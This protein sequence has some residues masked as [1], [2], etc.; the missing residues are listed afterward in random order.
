MKISKLSKLAIASFITFGGLQAQT[1][2]VPK[3][4]DIVSKII[5]PL[6]PNIGDLG[7][8]IKAD[9]LKGL[10][11]E[12]NFD[13]LILQVRKVH[14]EN[15]YLRTDLTIAFRNDKNS[16]TEDASTGNYDH[17]E[18]SITQFSIGISPGF[19]YHYAGTKRLS[20]YIG[21]AVPIAFVGKTK[22]KETFD[23]YYSNGT[24]NLST[25][26]QFLPGGIGFG[27]DGFVGLNYF[28]GKR[29]SIGLEYKLGFAFIKISG[30]EDY[31]RVN[32]VKSS[33]NGSET[34]NVTERTG[35]EESASVS[36]F[37]NKG[38]AGLNFVFY[39]GKN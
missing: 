12:N 21:A 15:I 28:V 11:W 7:F 17:R 1:T 27:L 38:V 39:L 24:Y 31:K 10:I 20:P 16:S 19:E 30:E 4:P 26:E 34:V 32:R 9:G 14:S 13:S 36:F 8:G 2:E 3:P 35:D 33:P 25:T 22:L 29:I 23:Q 18:E 5:E 37:G 6:K